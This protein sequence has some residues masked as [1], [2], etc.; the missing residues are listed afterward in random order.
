MVEMYSLIFIIWVSGIIL[1]FKM[2]SSLLFKETRNMKHVTHRQYKTPGLIMLLGLTVFFYSCT[3][4]NFSQPQP[5]DKENIYEFPKEFIGQ[6]FAEDAEDG[7]NIDFYLISK[8]Y[9]MVVLHDTER[10]VQGAWPK[11]SDTGAYLYPPDRPE[12]FTTINY[13]SLKRAVDTIANFLFRGQY[14][15]RIGHSRFL[16]KGY[17]YVIENDTIIIIRN[18]TICIDIGKNAFLRQLNK[19]IYVLNINKSILGNEY[20][21]NWWM[22]MLLEKKEDNSLSIWE[23]STKTANLSCMFYARPSAYHDFYF[24]CLWTTEEMLRLVKEGYF[25]ATS[26]NLK[27][28]RV[29]K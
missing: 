13:D 7:S 28:K 10:I 18:D 29:G 20:Y 19:N 8:K 22:L 9:A 15:H 14:I 21:N 5:V 11:L 4:Y 26:E 17:S 16:G 6:W 12:T 3:S 24:D 2:N 1:R 25:E 23:C 27:N